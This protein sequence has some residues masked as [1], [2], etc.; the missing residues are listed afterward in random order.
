[1]WYIIDNEVIK[2]VNINGYKSADII[3][4]KQGW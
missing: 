4:D 2:S 1:M 3:H